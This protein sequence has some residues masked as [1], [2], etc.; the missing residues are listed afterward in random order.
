M[1][2][3]LSIF[4]FQ[5]LFCCSSPSNLVI[6][7]TLWWYRNKFLYTVCCHSWVEVS[8]AGNILSSWESPLW[9]LGLSLIQGFWGNS[10]LLFSMTQSCK[11]VSAYGKGEKA[12]SEDVHKWLSL[13]A[14][15]AKL[16]V[17]TSLYFPLLVVSCGVAHICSHALENLY[18]NELTTFLEVVTPQT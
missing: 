14:L 17:F 5:D 4:I 11:W 12:Y 15:K 16:G 8:E 10:Q 1:G 6:N 2:I 7:I 9:C 3:Y 18:L 13:V